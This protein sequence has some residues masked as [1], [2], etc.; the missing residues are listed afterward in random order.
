MPVRIYKPARSAMQ[1]G[2]ANF[3]NWVLEFDATAPRTVDPLMG[4]TSS[5]DTRQQL[6]L[7]FDTKEEA[8]AYCEREGLA[9][10]VLPVNPVARFIK[11]SYSDNFKFGR[12]VNWTH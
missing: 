1:S 9:Y 3:D 2:K 6:K 12:S 8:I 5:A 4:W 7:T 11:K 10:H